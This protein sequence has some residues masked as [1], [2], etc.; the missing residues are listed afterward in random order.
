M[1]IMLQCLAE[2]QTESSLWPQAE[3]TQFAIS[4]QEEI[5]EGYYGEMQ[6]GLHLPSLQR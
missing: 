5:E 2:W 4:G 3:E 1:Q 6:E